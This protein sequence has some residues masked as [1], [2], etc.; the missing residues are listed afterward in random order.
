MLLRSRTKSAPPNVTRGS[1]PTRPAV[2]IG[3]PALC[4]QRSFVGSLG[5]YLS[6]IAPSLIRTAGSRAAALPRG[7]AR[8][9]S[10]PLAAKGSIWPL[11]DFESMRGAGSRG[12]LPEIAAAGIAALY[13]TVARRITVSRARAICW[14]IAVAAAIVGVAISWIAAIVV[15]SR[16][17]CS[18]QR[19][20][21]Q[22][23]AGPAPTTAA[24]PGA[25]A[26]PSATAA[27]PSAAAAVPSAAAAV[28]AAVPSGVCRRR[29]RRQ[30][31]SGQC[32]GRQR[33]RHSFE[34]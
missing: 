26:V 16:E 34:E 3:T 31:D 18:G 10:A 33:R 20:N 5:I 9:K 25:A 28:A 17:R 19:A 8:R 14:R 27:V 21:G 29:W 30:S 22:A 15:G 24:V 6:Y 7:A 1:R 13:V 23:N 2:A 12:S 32:E 4:A 11:T